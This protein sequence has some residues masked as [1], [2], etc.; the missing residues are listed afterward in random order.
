MDKENSEIVRTIITL[1]HNLGV[2]V[3]AE[4]VETS[5]Q[6]TEL[7]T[8]RCEYGQGYFFSNP[9]DSQV[10]EALVKSRRQWEIGLKTS[11]FPIDFEY[12]YQPPGGGK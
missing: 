12:S 6:L 7:R 4:G 11:Q 8:L 3:I 2:D 1:A 10:A 5:E 9:V